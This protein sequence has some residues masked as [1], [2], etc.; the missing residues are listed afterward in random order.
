MDQKSIG[1]D[2]TTRYQIVKCLSQFC[3]TMDATIMMSV[4]QPAPETFELFGEV[5]LLSEGQVVYHGPR[6][7]ILEFFESCGFTCPDRKGITDILQEVRIHLTC[8]PSDQISNLRSILC[9]SFAKIWQL[10]MG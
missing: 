2:N 9:V 7:H 8:S 3:H 5:V 4:L 10:V 6:E 1:L